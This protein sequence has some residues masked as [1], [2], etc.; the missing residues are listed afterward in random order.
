MTTH[1][2]SFPDRSA[3]PLAADVAGL[4]VVVKLGGA[5]MEEPDALDRWAGGVFD[6]AARGARVV[7]VHGGGAELTRMLSRLAIPTRF[8]GGHRVTPPEAAEI[9]EMVLSGSTH[10]AVTGALARAGV[11]A[12]GL[13]GG[14]ARILGVEPYRPGGLDLGRV[15]RVVLVRVDVL[16][17]LLDAGFVPVLSSTARDAG[18]EPYNVNADVVAG[19]VAAAWGADTVAFLSDVPAVRDRD[20]ATIDDLTPRSAGFLIAAGIADGGMRPKLEAAADAVAAGVATAVLADGRDP[21]LWLAAIGGGDVPCTRV[22]TE[23]RRS[24]CEGAS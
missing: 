12:V 9:A 8:E 7:V 24:A 23:K 16:D 11:D 13:A 15:G 1:P 21:A 19:A 6:L 18:G 14:D 2:L 4:R 17:R 5:A 10:R 20:G 3:S 22:R